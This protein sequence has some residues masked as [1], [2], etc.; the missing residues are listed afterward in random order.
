MQNVQIKHWVP[1]A[2]KASFVEIIKTRR[3]IRHK[4]QEPKYFP[5]VPPERRAMMKGED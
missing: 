5:P 1:S 3:W 2:E 4:H